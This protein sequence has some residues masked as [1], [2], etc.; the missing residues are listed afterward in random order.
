M[1]LVF[2]SFRVQ[3]QLHQRAKDR[4]KQALEEVNQVG[5]GGTIVGGGGTSDTPTFSL[6]SVTNKKED[7]KLQTL[8]S[9][10]SATNQRLCASTTDSEKTVD[11]GHGQDQSQ[12]Q[13]SAEKTAGKTLVCC[14]LIFFIRKTKCICQ[15]IIEQA[16]T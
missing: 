10:Q 5:G 11:Q 4:L 2:Y 12:S 6:P 15:K 1:Y 8:A 16:F 9:D 7:Q 14:C 3:D 13:R